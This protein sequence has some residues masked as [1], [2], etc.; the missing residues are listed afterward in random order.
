MYPSRGVHF[1]LLNIVFCIKKGDCAMS[2]V[3]LK[4]TGTSHVGY[5][6]SKGKKMVTPA[7]YDIF[8]DGVKVGCIWGYCQTRLS[9]GGCGYKGEAFGDT[10]SSVGV[11]GVDRKHM[12]AE[13]AELALKH[14]SPLSGE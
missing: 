8:L 5:Y 7:P 4:K 1:E 11:R 10:L 6:G 3:T 9:D 14:K 13:I 2:K 12:D